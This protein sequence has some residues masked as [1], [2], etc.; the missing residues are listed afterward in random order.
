MSLQ[1]LATGMTGIGA[2]AIRC[3]SQ[4]IRSSV[5]VARASSAGRA[6]GRF[7]PENRMKSRLGS[8]AAMSSAWSIADIESFLPVRLASEP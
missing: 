6:S 1:V 5:A 7:A 4:V 3:A 8:S 2:E